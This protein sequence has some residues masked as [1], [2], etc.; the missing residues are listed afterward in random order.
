MNDVEFTFLNLETYV[1]IIESISHN[2][3]IK[4]QHWCILHVFEQV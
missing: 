2:Y 4:M 3:I 1:W